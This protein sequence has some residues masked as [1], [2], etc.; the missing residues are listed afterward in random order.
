MSFDFNL[1][2]LPLVIVADNVIFYSIVLQLI[3]LPAIAAPFMFSQLILF[4]AFAPPFI[5][6]AHSILLPAEVAPLIPF[7]QFMLLPAV[8][9]PSISPS[10]L[11]SLSAVADSF[12]FSQMMLQ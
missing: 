11:I 6:P 7:V 1:L 12:I 9:F 8:A 4:P 2:F 10:H 5:L 3:P